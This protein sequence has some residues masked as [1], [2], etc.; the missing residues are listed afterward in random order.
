MTQLDPVFD[1]RLFERKRTAESKA[2]EIVAPDMME[3]R[4]LLGKLAPAPD[5]ISRQICADVEILA[6]TRD[7]GVAGLGNRE[8]RARFWVCLGKPQEIMR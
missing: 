4:R 6:Q 8:H 7:A 1:K 2:D 5:A 3:I